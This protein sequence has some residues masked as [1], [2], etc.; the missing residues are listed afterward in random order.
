M[1]WYQQSS[2]GSRSGRRRLVLA[3]VFVIVVFIIDGL[4]G[5]NIRMQ[6]RSSAATLWSA[7]GGV[8]EGIFGSGIFSTKRALERENARLKEELL[9]LNLRAMGFDVLRNENESL[10]EVAHLAESEK[11][12]TASVASSLRASPYGTFLIKAGT[13]NGVVVGDLVIIGDPAFGGFVI[14]RVSNAD[15]NISLV[16][17]L[18]APDETIEGVVRGVSVSLEGRGGEQAR[19]DVSRDPE[20]AQGD[21][22]ISPQLGGRA[23]GVV[24]VVEKE[25]GEAIQR[26]Y[27]RAPVNLFEVRFVYVLTE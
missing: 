18:F 8:G 25:A 10:R 9:Q 14:G 22:V 4:L 7:F 24:G 5:G 20:I 19:A 27:V 26:V 11:G 13:D 1:N 16:K 6:V 21:V 17:E 12:V 15:T 23:I 2:S 3:T